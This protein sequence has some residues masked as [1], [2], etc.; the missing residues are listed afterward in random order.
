M[1]SIIIPNSVKTIEKGAFYNCSLKYVDVGDGVQTIGDGAFM[2]C[3]NLETL[4][5]GESVS[6]IGVNVVNLE[7]SCTM[8]STGSQIIITNLVGMKNDKLSIFY[9][10]N[11]DAWDD[12]T[13][14]GPDTINSNI[15]TTEDK[16]TEQN[17][18]LY[19]AQKYYY[20]ENAP[21]TSGNYWHYVE[22]VPTVW[23]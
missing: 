11:I 12:M 5:I 6:S 19:K 16:W 15:Y 8:S 14:S 7:G 13:I 3:D 23:S 17:Y 21:T 1:E 9:K 20:S 4:I 10:G 18:A 2:Y 22:G